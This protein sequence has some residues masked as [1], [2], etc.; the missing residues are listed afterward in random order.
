MKLVDAHCHFDFPRFDGCRAGELEAALHNGVVGLVIP[1]VRSSDWDRVKSTAQAH[2]G[3]FY[4]L[5]IHPWYIGEHSERDLEALESLLSARPERC[6]AIGECGLDRLHGDLASQYPWFEAQ[7][8]LASKLNFPLIIHSVKT[9]DEVHA[10]LRRHN[11]SGRALL[12]GFSGSY[13]QAAKL[14]EQGCFIGVGG[15]ITHPRARKTRE[16]VA[17]LPLESLVLETDAPD[18]APEGI[19]A[20]NNSPAYLPRILECLAEIRSEQPEYLASVLFSNT[21]ELYGHSLW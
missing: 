2:S 11:W 15:V 7:I 4:C 10:T 8:E 6:I 1:G 13:Q 16:T 9:H 20:G 17:R 14:V 18:M 21:E 3:L 5:G 19:V 12:H